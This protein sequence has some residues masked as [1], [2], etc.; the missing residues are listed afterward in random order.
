MVAKANRELLTVRRLPI[1]CHSAI[2]DALGCIDDNMCF[3][4]AISFLGRSLKARSTGGTKKASLG[5]TREPTTLPPE[6][7]TLP[8]CTPFIEK[9]L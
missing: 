5:L 3:A 8:H 9:V 1:P 7:S 4:Y 2:Y 6:E